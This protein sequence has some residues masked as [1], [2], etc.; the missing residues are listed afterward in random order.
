MHKILIV[1]IVLLTMSACAKSADVKTTDNSR[2][3]ALAEEAF[4]ELDNSPDTIVD[5]V[6]LPSSNNAIDEV[7]PVDEIAE[8]QKP[9]ALNVADKK[10]PSVIGETKYPIENGY[11]IWVLNP[12]RITGYNYVAVGSAKDNGQGE[13]AQKQAAKAGAYAELSRM[14][15]V[16]V[17]NEIKSERTIH[18]INGNSEMLTKLDTYS[19]QRSNGILEGTEEVDIW[20]DDNTG[21]LYIIL[22]IKK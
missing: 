13:I 5:N 16:Q 8:K 1:L 11:P 9:S 7:E 18:S 4:N 21:E 17:E 3:I 14:I 19:R 22:G 6:T 12:N 20:L 10:R 15:S 2:T